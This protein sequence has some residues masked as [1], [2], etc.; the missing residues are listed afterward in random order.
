MKGWLEARDAKV[1]ML[2][3]SKELVDYDFRPSIKSGSRTRAR[4]MEPKYYPN[5][6]V[7]GDN[8]WDKNDEEGRGT[9]EKDIRKEF[10]PKINERSR[11]IVQGRPGS[12]HRRG[13]TTVP[14]VAKSFDLG[15][16]G[17]EGVNGWKFKKKEG[18]G[19]SKGRKKVKAGV[20]EGELDSM[21][22]EVDKL[23]LDQSGSGR[24]RGCGIGSDRLMMENV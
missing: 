7:F 1:Y 6:S 19:K 10:T 23:E 11:K 15:G 9:F 24:R 4:Y 8:W 21:M 5:V 22:V 18:G 3:R 2:Q 14:G 16:R 20:R 12:S 13:T 17:W